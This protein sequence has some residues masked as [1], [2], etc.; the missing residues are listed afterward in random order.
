MDKLVTDTVAT[1]L[2]PLLLASDGKALLMLEWEDCQ[3]RWQRYLARHYGLRPGAD[4]PRATDPG[5]L[6][7]AVAAW[8]AGDLAALDG[9]PL[10]P[11][12]TPFQQR[13]WAHLRTLAP[14]ETTSYAA[15]AEAVGLARNA[16]R[17]AGAANG[18]NPICV[19]IPC[20]RV[21]GSSGR[22]TGYSG[23]I[24]RKLWLL[25]H[26]GAPVAD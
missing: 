13:V 20:H 19:A 25:R 23:G 26:E 6:S 11:H 4:L 5:G 16:S 22:P 10:R 7:G 3:P 15:L 1:P 21:L 18:A 9:F 14:G 12:G 17:A 8:F 24:E 2:G